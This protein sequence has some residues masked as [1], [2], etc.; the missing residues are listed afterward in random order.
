MVAT[1][2]VAMWPAGPPSDQALEP[3]LRT[4]QKPFPSVGEPAHRDVV[5][6]PA[7]LSGLDRFHGHRTSIQFA[8]DDDVCAREF[9]NR[10]LVTL[11]RIDLISDHEGIVSPRLYALARAL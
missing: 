8:L 4:G 3:P 11:E 1:S 5:A 6:L 10:S 2:S 9:V 7:L